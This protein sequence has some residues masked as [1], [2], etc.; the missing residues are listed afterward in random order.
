MI[1]SHR[2]VGRTNICAELLRQGNYVSTQHKWPGRGHYDVVICLGVTK[3][4]HLH[5]GDVGV[6][7]LFTR[8]YQSLSPG[9]LFVLE[10]QPWSSYNRSRRASVSANTPPQVPGQ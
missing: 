8:A 3:W 1:S 4:V 6:V 5:W 9:G 10:P 7:R 2:D